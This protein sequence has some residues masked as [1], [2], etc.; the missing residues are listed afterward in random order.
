MGSLDGGG[1]GS[2]ISSVCRVGSQIV[3]RLGGRGACGEKMEESEGRPIAG[4]LQMSWGAE[5][6]G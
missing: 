6:L 4:L 5:S 2:G 1:Q 3:G